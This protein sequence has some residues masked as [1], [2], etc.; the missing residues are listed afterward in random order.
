[1]Y[2]LLQWYEGLERELIHTPTYE[3]D[4]EDMYDMMRHLK[5]YHD[6]LSLS[7]PIYANIKPSTQTDYPIADF[8][9]LYPLRK[10]KLIIER[11]V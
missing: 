7:K 4:Y 2:E 11:R 10:S 6:R 1:M 8:P 5:M 3:F 9:Q